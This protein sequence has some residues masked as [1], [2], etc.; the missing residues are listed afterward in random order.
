M[1]NYM[2]RTNL[3]ILIV[4]MVDHENITK[5]S[6]KLADSEPAN[7]CLLAQKDTNGTDGSSSSAPISQTFA[8]SELTQGY[9]LGTFYYGYATTQI[10]GG[11]MAERYGFKIIYGTSLFVTAILTLL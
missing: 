4:A 7:P 8:W 6:P 2:M 9:I 3:N 11:R 10:L 5:V 1:Q